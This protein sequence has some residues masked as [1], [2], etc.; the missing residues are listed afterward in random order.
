MP[1]GY[2][3][4]QKYVL[5][6]F[7]LPVTRSFATLTTTTK[8]PVSTCGVY[9]GLCLPRRR[10]AIWVAILP[11]TLFWASTTTQPCWTSSAFAVYVFIKPVL[12]TACLGK[13]MWQLRKADDSTQKIGAALMSCA[14]STKKEE[15]GGD[16]L[17]SH[18]AEPDCCD[19]I[20]RLSFG[21]GRIHAALHKP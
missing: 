9:S 15:I 13:P 1:P 5:R 4:C 16:E 8:S 20:R 3:V 18:Y 21:T 11:R 10:I 6:S 19:A 2:S 12:V 7:F 17:Q 14:K